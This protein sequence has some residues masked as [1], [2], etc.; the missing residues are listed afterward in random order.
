M[1]S[2]MPVEVFRDEREVARSAILDHAG[3]GMDAD[4]RIARFSE[5]VDIANVRPGAAYASSCLILSGGMIRLDRKTPEIAP[6]AITVEPTWFEGSFT[7]D[8]ET[9]WLSV[10]VKQERIDEIGQHLS[11]GGR[12]PDLIRREA[13]ADPILADIIRTCA[14]TL[15][16]DRPITQLELDGWAQVVGTHLLQHHSDD[17]IRVQ[18]SETQLNKRAL[19][20]LFEAIEEDI[21][22]DLSIARLARILDVG[23]T[24][25][26]L[27]FRAATG[28]TV[29]QYVIE[30]RVE[31]AREKL[32]TT[33]MPL[34]D[35][36]F[37]VGFSSQSHM[38]AVFRR[39]M[40]V[41]PGVYRRSFQR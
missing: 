33:D 15:L 14:T 24:K 17:P 18:R 39:Q 28:R 21:D 13:E 9:K 22:T 41:T 40:G 32:E 36:A 8:V 16:Q 23:T 31:R 34:A 7:N 4:L 12:A 3:F 27:G 38:T 6:G 1:S 5:N 19:R 25:L 29:H 37:A 30:R 35:I 11:V 26:S 2:R 10:Y 20:I